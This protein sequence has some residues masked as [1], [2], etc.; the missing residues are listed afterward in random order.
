MLELNTLCEP[1][2]TTTSP[3]QRLRHRMLPLE[4]VRQGHRKAITRYGRN[5]LDVLLR[6]FTAMIR[7]C[8]ILKSAS[9]PFPKTGL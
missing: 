1:T 5:E 2:M 9:K 7:I 8:I 6:A 3:Q 4:Q